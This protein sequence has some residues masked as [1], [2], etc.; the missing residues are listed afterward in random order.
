LDSDT[1]AHAVGEKGNG[2]VVPTIYNPFSKHPENVHFVNAYKNRYGRSP[3]TWA[4]QGYDAVKLLAY[5]MG[6]EV[7]STV[8]ANITIGLR[9]M[10][11]QTGATGMYAYENSGELVKKLIYF[12]ELQHE[13]FILFKSTKQEEQLQ[14]AQQIEIVDDRIIL[15]PEKPSESMEAI[16]AF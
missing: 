15:R 16:S 9:Y 14:Q 5:T 13:E 11:P 4:A 7:R 6:K 12:K 3:D 8:P 1:F 10:R 2:L